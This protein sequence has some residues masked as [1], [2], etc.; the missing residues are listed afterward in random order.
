[1]AKKKITDK[2]IISPKFKLLLLSMTL[3]QVKKLI[4]DYNEKYVLNGP[5]K[6]KLK[7]YSRLKKEQLI[8]FIDSSLEEKVK[9]DFFK[10]WEPEIAKKVI[11][12]ALLLISG[13]HKVEQIQN[14]G[15][16]QG[17]KGY[18]VWFKGK[19]GSNKASVDVS[20]D[21]NKRSC[22]CKI[23]QL[24]GICL[25]QM[26]IYLML[27]S[28]KVIN[29]E[30]LP[31]KVDKTWFEDVQKRLD[32]LATQSLFKEE[33][34]VMLSNGYRIFINGDFVTYQ[35]TGDYAGKRTRDISKE[36]EDVETWISKKVVD[37]MLKPI[38]TKT[39]EGKPEKIILDSYG[40]ISKIMEN[41]KLVNKILNKFAKLDLNL[42]TNEAELDTFLRS[43][44]KDKTK[45]IVIEPPFEA[46]A[47]DDPFL[48]VSYTHKDKA[49]VYPIL[50][51]LKENGINIW[52]DEGI[53]LSTDW[54]NTLAEK[55]IDC[56]I[57][58]SFI[59]PYILESENTKDEIQFAINEKKPYLAIYIK[60]TDLSPGLKMR[61]RR[62]QGIQKYD[63][64]E[65]QFYK[66]LIN[67]VKQML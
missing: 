17:G 54:C 3:A 2:K 18:R 51:K 49:Q 64:E 32:L 21:F 59:S 23:G 31:F 6:E 52:Y 60:E 58:L 15:I 45:E 4:D 62:I 43:N 66:K 63:M 35:W 46:Y 47:G 11:S 26:A 7:G 12:D 40:V 48:F 53:P 10:K 36:S 44:L 13:E 20:Q 50:R 57:F 30:D 33:P 8:E 19:Y 39:K 22:I 28:K 67:N 34:A 38:K 27:L 14:A 55:I 1:M 37:V 29:L 65:N 56:S 41:P 61:M 16:L 42:P 9:E 5:K 25:H 24:G